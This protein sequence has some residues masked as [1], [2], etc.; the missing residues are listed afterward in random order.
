MVFILFGLR[1]TDRKYKHINHQKIRRRNHF[2]IM[3]RYE[4]KRKLVQKVRKTHNNEK[5]VERP[6]LISTR[7]VEISIFH[8]IKSTY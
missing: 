2:K 4:E 5:K 1:D 8:I 7:G 3:K 6:A